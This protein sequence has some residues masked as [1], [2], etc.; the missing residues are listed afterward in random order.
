MQTYTEK[1]FEIREGDT[2]R[3]AD[4]VVPLILQ[5]TH[6]KSVIDVG[7]GT[8][9]WLEAFM[10]R[11]VTDVVGVDGD[12]VE[13]K[14]LRFPKDRFIPANLEESFLIDREFD[15]VLSLEVAEHL[16]IECAERF[17]E[18]LVKLG[19][20]IVFSAALPHQGG[21]HHVNEQWPDY[22]ANHFLRSGY[23][24][25]DALRKRIWQN[26]HVALWYRQNMLIFVNEE[27]LITYEALSG[28]YE[29]TSLQQ[30]CVVH[31]ELYI[32]KCKRQPKPFNPTSLRQLAK[33]LPA[34]FKASLTHRLGRLNR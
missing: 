30:L 5:L 20:I 4:E 34:L 32:N 21:T 24:A 33:M 14:M 28:E 25:I 8:G 17:V 18:S 31:P 12:Y 2:K 23:V 29:Q 26:D 16:S 6:A 27:L 1:F 11:G 22:W 15:L 7:C 3:S 13:R 10:E 9:D 19:P